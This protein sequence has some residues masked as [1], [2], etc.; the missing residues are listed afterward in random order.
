[1]VKIASSRSLKMK[2]RV[3]KLLVLAALPL[4]S[5]I[6]NEPAPCREPF[7]FKP[8]HSVLEVLMRPEIYNKQEVIIYGYYLDKDR[9]LYPSRDFAEGA[10][11]SSSIQ[12]VASEEPKIGYLGV[13]ESKKAKHPTLA[14]CSNHYVTMWGTAELSPPKNALESGKYE[15]SNIK[16][17]MV[18]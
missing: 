17:V 15:L 8:T 16:V 9:T 14:D 18:R 10:I 3:A 13:E 6:F 4:F 7:R 2:T 5:Y 12:V 11:Q 1:M